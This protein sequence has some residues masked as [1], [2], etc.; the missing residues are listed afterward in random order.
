MLY[1]WNINMGI[2]VVAE[3]AP[4]EFCREVQCADINWCD[5]AC[6]QIK[7]YMATKVVKNKKT[8]MSETIEVPDHDPKALADL[9][10]EVVDMIEGNK[11]FHDDPYKAPPAESQ[12]PDEQKEVEDHWYN[13]G[14]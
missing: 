5:T 14:F 9:H 1:L 6:N 4:K 8:G 3:P 12:A 10:K 2:K 13:Y 7:V 11:Q